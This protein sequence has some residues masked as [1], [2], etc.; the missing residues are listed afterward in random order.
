MVSYN[1]CTVNRSSTL[2]LVLVHISPVALVHGALASQTPPKPWRP[3]HGPAMCDPGAA[4]PARESLNIDAQTN[5]VRGIVALQQTPSFPIQ[6]IS[7]RQNF[8]TFNSPKRSQ[9]PVLGLDHHRNMEPRIAAKG[10]KRKPTPEDRQQIQRKCVHSSFSRR[11][12]CSRSKPV[13]VED[14]T[15]GHISATRLGGDS[16]QTGHAQKEDQR[17]RAWDR[18]YGGVTADCPTA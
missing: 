14:E 12:H 10:L 15:S 9:R 1:F 8:Q 13:A 11:G 18:T 2:Q 5:S 16:P 6:F 17:V 3:S 7:F 4:M